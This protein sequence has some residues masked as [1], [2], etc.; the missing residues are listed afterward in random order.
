LRLICV[1][2]SCADAADA[3]VPAAATKTTGLHQQLPW[4]EHTMNRVSVLFP[5]SVC[6]GSPPT[7]QG[8]TA[9]IRSHSAAIPP[10]LRDQACP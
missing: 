2:V 4:N 9:D 8:E 6:I 7:E 3:S 1:I 10:F 5:I